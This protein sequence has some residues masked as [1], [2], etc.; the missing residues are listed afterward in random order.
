MAFEMR[1]E[2]RV[3]SGCVFSKPTPPGD[4]PLFEKELLKFQILEKIYCF[5]IIL[6]IFVVCGRKRTTAFGIF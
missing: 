2:F 5:S 6:T 4:N 1:C 3:G